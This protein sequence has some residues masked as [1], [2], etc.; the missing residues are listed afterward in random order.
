METPEQ[1]RSP[2]RGDKYILR[3][4]EGLRDRVADAAKAA[5]RSMNAEF[6]KRIEESFD[7]P[8]ED[9]DQQVEIA[10]TLE[11]FRGVIK[12]IATREY[13]RDDAVRAM[14]GDLQRICKEVLPLI[15]DHVLLTGFLKML[16]EVGTA[17]Q[18]GDLTDAQGQL[19]AIYYSSMK[20][21]L[22]SGSHERNILLHGDLDEPKPKAKGRKLDI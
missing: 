6:V 2:Q 22:S 16:A 21:A 5:N 19:R 14:G 20:E 7:G 15:E 13:E 18:V 12:E 10:A 4:P 17:M 3:L 8:A 11:G 9:S 1:K